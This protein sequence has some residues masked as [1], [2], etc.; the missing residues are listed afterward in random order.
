MYNLEFK[1]YEKSILK[2][3]KC[4]DSI[5]M[6]LVKYKVNGKA[7]IKS[8]NSKIAED[9][10]P[11]FIDANSISTKEEFNNKIIENAITE[12]YS[13]E[14]I[15]GLYVE[16][17]AIYTNEIFYGDASFPINEYYLNTKEYELSEND[18]DFLLEVWNEGIYDE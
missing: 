12:D 5:E 9:I 10:I 15:I 1:A 6:K 11:F 3:F 4:E 2:N 16:I 13:K 8:F 7:L 18:K 14:D 17:N